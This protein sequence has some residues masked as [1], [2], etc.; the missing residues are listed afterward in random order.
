MAA[1]LLE[2]A[3][4]LRAAVAAFDPSLVSGDDAALV[5]EQ[6]AVT[7]KA[8]AAGRA[9][10]AVR[11]AECRSHER[12]GFAA[13]AE[14]LA[15]ATGSTPGDAQAA[16]AT[17]SVVGRETPAGAALAEGALSLEQAQVIARTEAECPGSEGELVQLARQSSLA[18][19]HDE[20]RRRRLVAADPDQLH[21][22]HH[23][24]REF[25]HWRDAEGMIRL[26][27]ALPPEVGVPLMNRLDDET[28]RIRRSASEREPHAAHAADALVAMTN[29][30]G[31]GKRS[32]ADLVL[33]CDLG[34]YRRGHADDGEPCHIVGGGPVPVSLARRLG[35]DAFVKAVLHDGVRIE[36]VAHF[37]RHIPA[38][39]RTALELGPPPHF[40]GV[41]CDEPGCGRR[42][43]LEWDHV[44]PVANGGPTSYD[45][46]RARCWPHHRAKTERDRR[47][48]LLG[49]PP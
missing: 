47:A 8:C 9:R 15:R 7:E 25:R 26:A 38:E 20:G 39:L 33:V 17:A 36:T 34:A 41:E 2:L 40:D 12:R 46:L 28:D 49:A 14:W 21:R 23:R 19:L 45:N 30:A 27:G 13:A 6:L 32:S 42:Y 48:G 22:R 29:G 5:A 4:A 24:A 44:D 10:A 31:T 43:G 3:A 1:T 37:G 35:A 11:A 18:K 16:M